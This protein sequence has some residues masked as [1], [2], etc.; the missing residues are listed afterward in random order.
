MSDKPRTGL[1]VAKNTYP[2]SERFMM[3]TKKRLSPQEKLIQEKVKAER[4]KRQKIEAGL[5]P[6]EPKYTRIEDLPPLHPDDEAEIKAKFYDL[7][8]RIQSHDIE[9]A[10]AEYVRTLEEATEDWHAM[11]CAI[12]GR[13]HERSD[14]K[15]IWQTLL[16]IYCKTDIWRGVTHNGDHPWESG[17][18]IDTPYA[19]EFETIVNESIEKV[20]GNWDPDKSDENC[21]GT[22]KLMSVFI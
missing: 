22:N 18:Y 7:A 13:T 16:G 1:Q 15:P 11:D 6:K 19:K 4:V 14:E 21:F 10:I 2:N 12:K 17:R 3:R 5:P 20:W 9:N 8:A